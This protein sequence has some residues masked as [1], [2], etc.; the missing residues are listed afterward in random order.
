M[1]IVRVFS[2]SPGL[3]AIPS[4]PCLR[5]PR[6]EKW[7]FVRPIGRR[8][9]TALVDPYSVYSVAL[10]ANVATTSTAF[11]RSTGN[12]WRFCK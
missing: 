5:A 7:T 11:F 1:C 12:R 4:P 8:A 6:R 2:N 9:M 10:V 3:V